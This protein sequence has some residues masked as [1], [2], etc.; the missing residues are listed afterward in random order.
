MLMHLIY[1]LCSQYVAKTEDIVKLVDNTHIFIMPSMNPDGYEL[2]KRENAHGIDLNR[3]FPDQYEGYN[4]APQPESQALMQWSLGQHFVLS[5]NMHG[6][7][8]VANY[9]Y[10]GNAQKRSGVYSA[11]P[12]DDIFRAIATT[13]ASANPTMLASKEF[14]GGITNGAQ[15]YILYGGMQDWNYLNTHSDMEI[16]VELS[17]TKWPTASTLPN[18]WND[19]RQSLINYMKYVHNGVKGKVDCDGHDT[20]D[21]SIIVKGREDAPYVTVDPNGWYFRLLEPGTYTLIASCN[22]GSSAYLKQLPSFT[23]T[24]QKPSTILDINFT[25]SD[26]F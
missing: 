15:W 16:T 13:F 18:Y 1:E 5:A 11:S 9:P 3:D 22:T 26:K 10:D 7:S 19:N 20:Y 24:A 2:R 25:S 23:L 12:D 21:V 8:I 14:P 17:N 4:H 6:G